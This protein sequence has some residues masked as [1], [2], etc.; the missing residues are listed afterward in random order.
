MSGYIQRLAARAMNPVEPIHPVLGSVFAPPEFEAERAASPTEGDDFPWSRPESTSLAEAV[1][2]VSGSVS[3][4]LS[5]R[6]WPESSPTRASQKPI[7]DVR[8]VP[9]MLIRSEK[10]PAQQVEQTPRPSFAKGT[11]FTA[12]AQDPR[13]PAS[14]GESRQVEELSRQR[15]RPEATSEPPFTPL[16][17]ENFARRSDQD[18]SREE[19]YALAAAA[20]EKGP[21]GRPAPTTRQPDEIQIHIGRIEVTAIPQ[22]APRTATKPARKGINLEEYLSRRDRR[23]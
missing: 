16:I 5:S 23:T 17:K 4:D 21:S 7:H 20:R 13:Q 10:V 8:P 11:S 15:R 9:G 18:F 19:T 2:P 22:A 1:Q 12:G 14:N 3:P 6:G